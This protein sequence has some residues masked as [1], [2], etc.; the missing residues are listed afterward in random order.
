MGK[1]LPKTPYRF[2]KSLKKQPRQTHLEWAEAN[3]SFT[4]AKVSPFPGKFNSARSAHLRKVFEVMDN[5]RARTIALMWA[6]QTAKT[7]AITI[8]A[9]KK[10]VTEASF[11]HWLYPVKDKVSDLI[12]IKLDPVLRSM[13]IVWDAMEDFKAEEKIREKRTI[14]EVAGGG[15]YITGTTANDL[16]SISVPLTIGD[17]IGEMEKGVM[18]EATERQKSF[19]KVFPRTIGASTMVHPDDE[20]VSMHSSCECLLEYHMICSECNARYTRH[21]TLFAFEEKARQDKGITQ[22]TRESKLFRDCKTI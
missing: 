22:I 10:L 5:P 19:S 7:L 21:K 6:S 9:A 1:L 13:P 2:I 14:K 3:L 18:A 17:E 4:G 16:K 20:I 12:R 15:L 11:I 8:P